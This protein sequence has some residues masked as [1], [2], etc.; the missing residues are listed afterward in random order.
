MFLLPPLFRAA[1]GWD[2]I[3]RILLSVLLLAPLGLL[4]GMPFPLGMRLVAAT[5]EN[6]VPWAWAVNGCASV[7]GSILSVM[8]AQSL[9]F[10]V[11][12]GIALVVY[13]TGL[14][15]VLTLRT[16]AQPFAAAQAA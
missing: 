5:N 1:L 14:A 4:M 15:A 6:L 3:P 2:L 10:T 8:L 7:L 13:L 11:V 12:L 16:H 9:G